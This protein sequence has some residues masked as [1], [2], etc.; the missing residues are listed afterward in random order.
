MVAVIGGA[1][2]GSFLC[3]RGA[4]ILELFCSTFILPKTD[5]TL[6]RIYDSYH[7]Y[8][9]YQQSNIY[10]YP[11]CNTAHNVTNSTACLFQPAYPAAHMKTVKNIEEQPAVNHNHRH[12]RQ[13]GW[14]RGRKELCNN[15]T[16]CKYVKHHSAYHLPRCPCAESGHTT[17]NIPQS[18]ASRLVRP[19]RMSDCTCTLIPPFRINVYT[20]ANYF[21]Q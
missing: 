18:Y 19:Q 4:H 20:A 13:N 8:T 11:N 10:S 2:N 1:D 14:I 21:P 5:Q 17:Q 7:Y 15:T 9:D 6:S 3:H 16:N 12:S